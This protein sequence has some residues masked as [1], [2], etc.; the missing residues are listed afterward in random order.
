MPITG[1]TSISQYDDRY[2]N[3]TG[4]TI[5]GDLEMLNSMIGAVLYDGVNF[6][7]IGVDTDGHLTTTQV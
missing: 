7:R 6:W 5:D 2:V 4:D 3:V 1:G